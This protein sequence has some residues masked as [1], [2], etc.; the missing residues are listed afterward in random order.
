MKRPYTEHDPNNG[1]GRYTL[2][3]LSATARLNWQ[4]T[5]TMELVSITAY[6]SHDRFFNTDEDASAIGVFGGFF[7]FDDH[8]TSDADQITQELRLSG[9]NGGIDWLLGFFYFDEDRESTST[10]RDFETVTRPDTSVQLDTQSWAVFGEFGKSLTG[11]LRVIGGIRYTDEDKETAVVTAGLPGSQQLD[12]TNVSGK[13]GLEWRPRDEWMIYG[14]FSTGFRS[15]NFNTDLLLG[16]LSALTAV[17]PEKVMSFELGSK[18]TLLDGRMRLNATLFYQDVTDKQGIVY[19]AAA[20]AP[21]SRLISVG[22]TDIFGAEL[23]LFL[24]PVENLELSLGVGW[25]DTEVK[26]PASLGFNSNFGTGANAFVGDPFFLD[27]SE[28]GGAGLDHQ[29][30]GALSHTDGCPR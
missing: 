4:L 18:S 3:T 1:E 6:D 19:D 20:A 30:A 15:G 13:V 7:S 23:E 28:L 14:T 17:D 5:D 21:V 12:A 2:E 22:D 26:A 27:G 29:W 16:D 8:Y 24:V 25:L 9:V 10:I 11:T